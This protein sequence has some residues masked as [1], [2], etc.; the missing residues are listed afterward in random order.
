MVARIMAVADCYDAL[1]TDRPYRK[2]YA[3]EEVRRLMR[4][5]STEGRL[6]GKVMDVLMAMLGNQP[7]EER[8]QSL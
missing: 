7:R 6:D 5:E 3:P 1:I 8:G 2:A 4:K